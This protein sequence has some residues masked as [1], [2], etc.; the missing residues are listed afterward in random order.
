MLVAGT[1][2]R[3]GQITLPRVVRDRLKLREGDKV[4][5]QI[6]ETKITLRPAPRPL[7]EWKG[8]IHVDGPQDLDRVRE[9]ALELYAKEVATDG[10]EA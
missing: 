9:R 5:F 4:L 1:V 6:E 7:H 10:D 3:R 8:S 2:G